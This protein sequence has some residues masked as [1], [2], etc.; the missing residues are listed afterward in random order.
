[1]NTK[2]TPGPWVID[3]QK[4]GGRWEYHIRQENKKGYGLGLHIATLNPYLVK[5]ST[6]SVEANSHLFAAA[7]DLLAALKDANERIALMASAI[8]LTSSDWEA[9]E[10]IRS[11]SIQAI[12]KNKIVIAKAESGVEV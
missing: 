5:A 6:G 7:P 12:E 3:L 9:I 10:N 2:H 1:M 4:D 8:I 11:E